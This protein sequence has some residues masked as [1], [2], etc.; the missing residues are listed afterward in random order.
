MRFLP[1]VLLAIIPFAVV[2]RAEDHCEGTTQYDM[3]M[4]TGRE[5]EKA[6]A[7]LNERYS[8]L[9][10]RLDREDQ[11]KLRRAQRAWIS[12]RDKVCEFETNGLGSVRPMIFAGCLTKWTEDHIKYLDYQLSCEEGDLSC[13]GWI[14]NK[15]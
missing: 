8:K 12:Y 14:G 2:A 11:E 7:T 6:D 15:N 10:K 4:C 9:M 3:N 13:K 1:F 5:F